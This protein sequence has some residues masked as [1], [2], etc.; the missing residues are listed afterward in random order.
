MLF[1]RYAAVHGA[2]INTPGGLVGTDTL[3]TLIRVNHIDYLPL[4]YG[5]VGTL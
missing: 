3:G 5:A 1:I 2:D 4:T